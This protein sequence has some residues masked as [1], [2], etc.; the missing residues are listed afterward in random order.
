MQDSLHRLPTLVNKFFSFI[1]LYKIPHVNYYIILACLQVCLTVRQ[2]GSRG[3]IPCLILFS[4]G[5]NIWH[6]AV[7]NS[8]HT[9]PVS[10]SWRAE[11]HRSA[12]RLRVNLM[13]AK[14]SRV[15]TATTYHAPMSTRY[16]A[17]VIPWTLHK[18]RLNQTRK[19]RFSEAE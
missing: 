3:E 16:S 14:I 17:H 18:K 12:K 6:F 11:E 15:L 2:Q 10:V 7:I 4:L 9:L 8:L 1:T 19:L 5:V 13:A